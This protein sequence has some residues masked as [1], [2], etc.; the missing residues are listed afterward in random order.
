MHFVYTQL[1]CPGPWINT[2][3]PISPCT[4]TKVI[5]AKSDP[6]AELSMQNSKIDPN[7][8]KTDPVLKTRN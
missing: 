6:L 1:P 5:P 3:N 2:F 8:S 7:M 4:T